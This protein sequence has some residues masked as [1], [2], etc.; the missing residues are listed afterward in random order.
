M[1]RLTICANLGV[2]LKSALMNAP[3]HS[4]SLASRPCAKSS[5]SS[6][7]TVRIKKIGACRTAETQQQPRCLETPI[8]RDPLHQNAVRCALLLEQI[9]LSPLVCPRSTCLDL[10][11]QSGGTSHPTC[12]T[13]ASTHRLVL[14]PDPPGDEWQGPRG[15]FLR[16]ART[17]RHPLCP[18]DRRTWNPLR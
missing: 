18:S 5:P 3:K 15:T 16:M 2:L 1:V 10:V 4:I 12:T 13:W 8:Q 9:L 17:A 6:S 7:P 11:Q 14:Q